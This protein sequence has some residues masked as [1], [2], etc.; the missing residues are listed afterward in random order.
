MIGSQGI[1]KGTVFLNVQRTTLLDVLCYIEVVNEVFRLYRFGNAIDLCVCLFIRIVAIDTDA[2]MLLL[3]VNGCTVI[4]EPVILHSSVYIALGSFFGFLQSV[5]IQFIIKAVF[6]VMIS[7]NQITTF[8]LCCFGADFALNFLCNGAFFGIGITPYRMVSFVLR[9]HFLESGTVLCT[10]DRIKQRGV[11]QLHFPV[12]DLLHKKSGVVQIDRIANLIIPHRCFLIRLCD[13]ICGFFRLYCF[14]RRHR[15]TDFLKVVIGKPLI[16]EVFRNALMVYIVGSGLFVP[17]GILAILGINHSETLIDIFQRICFGIFDCLPLGFFLRGKKATF[18]HQSVDS[19]CHLCPGHLHLIAA[20][21]GVAN[22][23]GIVILT[24]VGCTGTCMGM[25]AGSIFMLQ[26]LGFVLN[27]MIFLPVFIDT[28]L[29]TGE[30]AATD[31]VCIDLI[32]RNKLTDKGHLHHIALIFPE[33]SIQF[34]QPLFNAIQLVIVETKQR[35]V[36]IMG[37]HKPTILLF[38]CR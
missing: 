18:F 33:R 20:A 7:G 38:H 19:L 30:A 22:A 31:Q 34:I 15:L 17:D 35:M 16:V 9:K 24:A 36:G 32:I 28:T 6:K 11:S 3:I 8:R 26:K 27:R 2:L 25:T 10:E 5:V 13:I 12:G 37:N 14:H 21:F 1:F 4:L 23:L 29:S